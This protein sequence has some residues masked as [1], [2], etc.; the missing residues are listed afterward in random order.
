MKIREATFQIVKTFLM[1]IEG[2]GL[3]EFPIVHK[4]LLYY[5]W[6]SFQG[7]KM[8]V[9]A[10]DKVITPILLNKGVWE[11]DETKLFKRV[12]EKGMTVVDLGANIGWYTLIAAKLVGRK[13]K[14]YAF[15]PDPNNCTLLR[16]NVQ[17]N[18]YQNVTVEQKAVLDRCGPVKL[19]L[20]CDN[21]G[22]HRIYDSCD[23]RRCITTEGI[24]LDDYFK[25]KYEKIDVIKIDIQGAEMSALLGMERIIKANDKLK[26]FIEFSPFLIMRSG[27]S[28]EDFLNKLLKYGFKIYVINGQKRI[29]ELMHV[30]KIMELC[31]D[32]PLDYG[33]NLFLEK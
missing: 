23:G 24:I 27:F 20:S 7:H 25:D 26:M 10:R 31:N 18:G 16:K 13:G 14:V 22:D 8:Y 28:P 1:P 21:L 3:G 33:I 2:R 19:F 15:E 17:T 5:R 29:I 32:K 12:I 11:E 6:A 9:N 30:D 4:I